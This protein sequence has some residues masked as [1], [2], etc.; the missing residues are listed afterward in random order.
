METVKES[1]ERINPQQI[2]SQTM[3][4]LGWGDGDPVLTAVINFRKAVLGA[5]ESL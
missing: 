3:E 2:A 5:I 1:I 4:D